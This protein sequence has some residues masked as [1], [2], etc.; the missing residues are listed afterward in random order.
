MGRANEEKDLELALEVVTEGRKG[1]RRV[2]R[3]FSLEA[4]AGGDDYELLFTVPARRQ[5]RLR[6][7][8][9]LARGLTFTRIGIVT[10][11]P[12]IVLRRRGRDEAL[13]ASFAHFGGLTSC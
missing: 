4:A 9:R 3:E 10:R 7:V 2:G 12:A 5:G 1:L 11:D 8:A 6:G 13:P